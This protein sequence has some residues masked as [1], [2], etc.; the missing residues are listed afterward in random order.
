MDCDIRQDI[1]HACVTTC[2]TLAYFVA[3]VV[4]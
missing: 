3:V 1:Y 4:S 2:I